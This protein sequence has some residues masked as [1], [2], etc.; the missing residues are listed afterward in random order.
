MTTA[1][2]TED[3][4]RAA[5][6]P[7]WRKQAK[8]LTMPPA[9]AL[10]LQQ[11]ADE[12]GLK[13][14]TITTSMYST[15]HTGERSLLRQ[16]AR[17][18]YD[19][20]GVPYWEP[21]QVADYFAQIERRFNVRQEFAHLTTVDRIGAEELQAASLHGLW[22]LSTIPVGTLHRWKLSGGFPPPIAIMEV[23]SPTPRLLYSWPDFVAYVKKHRPRWL[24]R[25]P[26]IN[27]DD[28]KLR[29]TRFMS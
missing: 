18:A 21:E 27:L 23:E 15:A 10:A 7:Q 19:V 3:P 28:P 6:V 22:R 2:T 13:P 24:V 11:V 14:K 4:P 9:D 5:R 16:I 8:A 1:V 26:D 20:H 17:P 25:H 29:V 12:T